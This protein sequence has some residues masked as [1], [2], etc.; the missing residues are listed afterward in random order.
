MNY[1]FRLMTVCIWITLTA[2]SSPT[3]VVR[4]KANLYLNPD[5][6]NQSLPVQ[7]VVYQLRDP[8]TFSQATFNELWH[9]DKNT[10][11]ASL[12]S[13]REINVIPGSSNQIIINRDHDAVYVGIMAIY[14]NPRVGHWRLIKKLGH[15]IPLHSLKIDISLIDYSLQ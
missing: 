1:F 4:L 15:S 12:I 6:A 14:R 10:L 5:I 11:G 8:Q 7:V 2:C 13:R 9:D 3:L